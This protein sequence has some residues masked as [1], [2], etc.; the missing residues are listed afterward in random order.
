MTAILKDA[1]ESADS[2]SE[3]RAFSAGK[4]SAKHDV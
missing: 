2:E 3:W 4:L 1:L